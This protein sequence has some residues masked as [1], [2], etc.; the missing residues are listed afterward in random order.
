HYEKV[1][2]DHYTV[3]KIG[4][5]AASGAGLTD[6]RLSFV[7]A[8]ELGRRVA[9][10]LGSPNCERM[11]P[12]KFAEYVEDNFRNKSAVKVT[13]ISD[14]DVIEKEYPLLHAVARCSLSGTDPIGG[15]GDEDDVPR[16]VPRV[17][18]LEYRSDDISKVK[19]SLYFIGKGVTYDTGG[20]DIKAGGVMRGMSRDKCGA[21]T[22]AGFMATIAELK[23]KH[24][25]VTVVLGLVRNSVGSNAYVSDEIIYSRAGKRVLVGNT[26]AEGRMVMTDLLCESKEAVL[27]ERKA[28]LHIPS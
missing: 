3:Q 11:T 22:A 13:V 27:E 10:D 16:H 12:I 15:G 5:L 6:G 24:V 26:D 25:N 14:I 28:G 9:K 20:A 1:G 4:V 8:V 7:N 17:V 21:A 2:K 18:K 23:P 19:E